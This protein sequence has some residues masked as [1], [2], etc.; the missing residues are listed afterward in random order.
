MQIVWR[1]QIRQ[2]RTL[3][4]KV[5]V[6]SNHQYQSACNFNTNFKDPS[7]IQVSRPEVTTPLLL[8][9]CTSCRLLHTSCLSLSSNPEDPDRCSRLCYIYHNVKSKKILKCI[10]KAFVNIP[11]QKDDKLILESSVSRKSQCY[12]NMETT[13]FVF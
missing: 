3:N 13:V 10:W 2:E 8:E 12:F 7:P 11:K 1:V 6:E 4:S 9:S 5:H